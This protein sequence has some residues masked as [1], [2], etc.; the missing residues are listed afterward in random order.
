MS[1]KGREALPYGIAVKHYSED[2]NACIKYDGGFVC[3]DGDREDA[4]HLVRAIAKAA[5]AHAAQKDAEIERLKRALIQIKNTNEGT[6]AQP[7]K[8]IHGI[9]KDALAA[10]NGGTDDK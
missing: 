6:I 8:V 3:I 4:E 1:D 5:L 7:L 10:T 9:A 2:E